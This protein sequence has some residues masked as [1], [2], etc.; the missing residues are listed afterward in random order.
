MIEHLGGA[1]GIAAIAAIFS[2]IA[3]IAAAISAWRGPLAA[4]ELADNLRSS[5]E[6]LSDRRRAKLN[7]F[8]NL[9][10]S[11]SAIWSHEAVNALNLIDVVYN[12]SQDVRSAWAELYLSFDPGIPDH[13]RDEKVRL[14]LSAMSRDLNLADELRTDDF[15]RVYIP[16][17]IVEERQLQILER[18]RALERFKG[19]NSPAANTAGPSVESSLFPPKPS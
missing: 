19:E 8:G 7:V 12:D 1:N 10:A 17:A 13:Y 16:N 9:M 3:G 2:A 18:K 15:G 11:R 6:V 5:G 14:L 4:A